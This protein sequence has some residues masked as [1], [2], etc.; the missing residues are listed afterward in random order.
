MSAAL[1]GVTLFCPTSALFLFSQ[2]PPVHN[3]MSLPLKFLFLPIF[4]YFLPS[5]MLAV[6]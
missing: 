5:E 3:Q 4:S 1:I 2:L 6:A